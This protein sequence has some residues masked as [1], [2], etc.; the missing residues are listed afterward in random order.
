MVEVHEAVCE[1]AAR[2]VRVACGIEC[3]VDVTVAARCDALD[4]PA[5]GCRADGVA[6]L[7]DTPCVPAVLERDVDDAV[8]R[9]G[10]AAGLVEGGRVRVNGLEGPPGAIVP[11][12]DEQE[13]ETTVTVVHVQSAQIV[14]CD[15]SSHDARRHSERFDL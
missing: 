8:I 1:A 7:L 11:A 3:D 4:R 13:G 10:Y 6:D 14:D 9:Y 2:D 12:I 15:F 5:P